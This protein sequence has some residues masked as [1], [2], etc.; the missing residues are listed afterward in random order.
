[1]NTVPSSLPSPSSTR[2]IVRRLGRLGSLVV[3][4]LFAL[5]VLLQVFLLWELP[6]EPAVRSSTALICS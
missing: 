1:M 4:L 3:S 5:G 6:L 2:M